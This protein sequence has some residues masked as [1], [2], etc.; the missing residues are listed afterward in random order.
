MKARGG[1]EATI[2][3]NEFQE[4]TRRHSIHQ[5]LL[6]CRKLLKIVILH[7]FFYP[8]SAHSCPFPQKNQEGEEEE[9]DDEDK[10]NKLLN[11][12]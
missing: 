6:K 5:H 11:Q 12:C 7:G 2:D 3:P 1:G 8:S 4:E 10:R 9:E